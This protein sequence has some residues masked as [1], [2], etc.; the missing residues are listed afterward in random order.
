MQQSERGPG[1]NTV[2]ITGNQY[3]QQSQQATSDAK[4]NQQQWAKNS[5]AATFAGG[6]QAQP[7][8]KFQRLRSDMIGSLPDSQNN[9]DIMS[10]QSI[11]SAKVLSEAN[12]HNQN[13]DSTAKNN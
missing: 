13:D 1:S 5:Q 4:R 3:Q 7:Q 6:A 10:Y 9:N 11:S 2:G 8:Q 12:N